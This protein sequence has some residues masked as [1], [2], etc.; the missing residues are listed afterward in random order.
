M[1]VQMPEQER[2]LSLLDVLPQRSAGANSGWSRMT[3]VLDAQLAATV[4]ADV[5]LAAL[6][7]VETRLTG[8]DAQIATKLAAS[9]VE[10][11][12]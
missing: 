4:D 7:V 8:H 11:A 5:L 1:N 3:F 10:Q 6:V 12:E 9:G 2:R